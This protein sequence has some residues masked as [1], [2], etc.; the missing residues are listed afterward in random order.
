MANVT[1]S[2]NDDDLIL[3]F[4]EDGFIQNI[5]TDFPSTLSNWIFTVIT[6]GGLIGVNSMVLLVL[7]LKVSSR[8]IFICLMLFERTR[9]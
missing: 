8:T 3:F 9:N 6:V 5:H 4:S 7:N 2:V 1:L